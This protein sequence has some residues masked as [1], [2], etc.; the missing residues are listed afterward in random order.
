MGRN[1][2]DTVWASTPNELRNRKRLEVTLPPEALE[3]LE[4]QATARGFSRSE[5]L[6][7]L[8]M[9]APIREA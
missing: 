3:R 2:K 9:A 1:A 5:V 6:E 4:K 7:A 8:I